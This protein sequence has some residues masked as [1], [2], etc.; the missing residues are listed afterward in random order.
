MPVVKANSRSRPDRNNPVR[1][2][3]PAK[4]LNLMF[5]FSVVSVF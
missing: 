1:K 5:V 3:W 2:L 4:N